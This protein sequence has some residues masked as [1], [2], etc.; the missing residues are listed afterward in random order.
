LDFTVTL[1]HF[2]DTLIQIHLQMKRAKEAIN[3]RQVI[4]PAWN[5]QD[6]G[7]ACWSEE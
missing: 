1:N 6:K 4:P 3:F 2:A 5:S 7:M